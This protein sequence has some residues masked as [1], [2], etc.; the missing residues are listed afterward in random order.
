MIDLRTPAIES[1]V[2]PLR[3]DVEM[4][5]AA[6][7]LVREMMG[8]PHEGAE[9]AIR[10]WDVADAKKRRPLWPVALWVALILV[11]AVVGI[12]NFTEV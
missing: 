5:L 2:R 3:D 1:A 6:T 11:S 4:Q 8:S 12:R 10:R 9:D 7:H